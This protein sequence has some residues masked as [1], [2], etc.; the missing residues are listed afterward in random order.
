MLRWKRIVVATDFSE[1]AEVA[2]RTAERLAKVS[3]G[4]VWAVHVA[5][6]APPYVEPLLTRLGPP[7]PDEVWLRKARGEM[8][9]L[10]AD[11]RR[12]VPDA[13]GFVR[14]G[15]PWRHV[16]E[17]AEEVDADGICLGVS[18]H[19]RIDRMLM[20]TTAEAVIRHSPV[21]VMVTRHEPLGTVHSV[22]LPTEMDEGSRAAIRYAAARFGPRVRLEAFHVVPS[23][24]L[25]EPAAYGDLPTREDFE[26]LLREFLDGIEGGERV[27]GRVVMFA[28]PAAAIVE[29]S[30]EETPDLIVVA[31][32]GRRGVAR[33]LLGSV[34]EKIVRYTD[35]PVLVL[36][37]PKA[38]EEGRETEPGRSRTTPFEGEVEPLGAKP[39]P[40]PEPASVADAA[41]I[42]RRASLGRAGRG[43]WS[44]RAHTGRGGPA[45][46]RGAG[47]KAGGGRS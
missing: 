18:G 42:R 26:A 4:T 47:S 14:T 41:E 27:A 30:R 35:A 20:G 12:R 8:A 10:L 25:F 34:S 22:L 28:D 37:G 15:T 3:G 36:P 44:D 19:S 6:L 39:P 46:R 7:D 31:T 13:R 21:P 9:E 43:P 16:I 40:R 5:D 24:P 11:L 1:R 23:W 29:A 32:H 33:A 38:V 17:L 2:L 45:G